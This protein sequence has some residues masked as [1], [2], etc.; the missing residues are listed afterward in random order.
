[1]KT[2]L[3]EVKKYVGEAKATVAVVAGLAA[4]A[5]S[6][7]VLSGTSKDVAEFVLSVATVLGVHKS[8]VKL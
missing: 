2:L 4:L 8:K 6:A 3:A 5:V 1:M 7:G